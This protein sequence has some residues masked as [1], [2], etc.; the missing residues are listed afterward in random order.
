MELILE[1]KDGKTESSLKNAGNVHGCKEETKR[2]D[3]FVGPVD[4]D[5]CVEAVRRKETLDKMV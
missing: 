2:V 5:S 3:R 1:I 4:V